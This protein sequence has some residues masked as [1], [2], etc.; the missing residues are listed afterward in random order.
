S[1][2]FTVSGSHVYKDEV[3]GFYPLTVWAQDV[4]APPETQYLYSQYFNFWNSAIAANVIDAP[5]AATAPGPISAVEG[6][7]F[8]LVTSF[9]D[10]NPYSSPSDYVA[11]IDWGGGSSGDIG[12]EF[13]ITG[14]GGAFQLSTGHAYTEEGTYPVTITI[15]DSDSRI[16]TPYTPQ[17]S[18]TTTVT[19]NHTPLSARH[20]TGTRAAPLTTDEGVALTDVPLA[21]FT[22][23]PDPPTQPPG[24]VITA[25]IDWGDGTPFDTQTFTSGGTVAV[26]GSHTYAED[27]DYRVTVS[28]Y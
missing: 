2:Q 5:L 13:A 16:V 20:V 25:T 15:Y 24:Q 7:S 17:V 23:V 6:K 1:G 10:A 14:G 26:S 8:P 28:L 21:T 27:G 22:G 9:T 4:D 11:H 3:T 18:V 12:G 19:V